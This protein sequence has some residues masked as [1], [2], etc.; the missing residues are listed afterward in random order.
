MKRLLFT[1]L[2]VAMFSF[3]SY[4]Q[5][6]FGI[7]VAPEAGMILKSDKSNKLG[8]GG[9][10]S[11]MYS[12]NYFSSENS[13]AF[14][15]TLK[16]F[17]NPWNGGKIVSS[18]LNGKSDAFNYLSVLAGYQKKIKS[19]YIEPRIGF[20]KGYDYTAFIFS[21]QIG[22]SYRNF[23]FGLFLD[24]AAGNEE[25]PIGGKGFNTLGLS[26]GYFIPF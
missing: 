10:I 19:Y 15:I 18:I 1:M 20:A 7:K 2:L 24:V 4:S 5:Y 9:T 17:N 23:D 26:I 8:V 3:S 21:P 14:S 25:T 13:D 12:H 11:L 22:Y 16:G 6:Q